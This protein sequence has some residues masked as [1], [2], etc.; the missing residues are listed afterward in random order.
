MKTLLFCLLSFTYICKS[1]EIPKGAKAL[2]DNYP[3]IKTYENNRIIFKDGSSLLYDDGKKK[4][5]K[6]L[7][8]NPDLEDQFTYAYSSDTSFKPL[9]VNFDPG[10]IRNEEF[11]KK[12][13]GSKKESVRSNL[14]SIAWC[15]KI[16]GQTIRITNVNGIAEKVK[17]LSADI[18]K[19]PEFAKYI[20]NIGG[21]FNWRNIAGTSRI[22]MHSFGMTI[23]INTS[24]SHYWQWDCDCTNEDAHVKY[25]NSIP[26]KLVQIFEKH[27][28]I[29]G[30]KWYHYDT[31]HFEYRPELIFNTSK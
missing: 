2:I 10:R 13:Y 23:D 22:S 21:T 3:Q 24:F 20:K 27:G 12:I 18:D 25:K 17:Q 28:F 15:P 19:H 7:L 31:M 9:Q 4:S 8:E 1:E 29:W 14:K 11:F 26:L 30:G 16:A 5:V 6:E